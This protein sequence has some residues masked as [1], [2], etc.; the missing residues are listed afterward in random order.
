MVF[1]PPYDT[2]LFLFSPHLFSLSRLL[3]SLGCLHPTRINK[4]EKAEKKA[5][6]ANRR[7]RCSR[8]LGMNL[9]YYFCY[10][11]LAWYITFHTCTHSIGEPRGLWKCNVQSHN[12]MWL[13]FFSSRVVVACNDE[14]ASIFRVQARPS[15]LLLSSKFARGKQKAGDAFLVLFSS[16]RSVT[17]AFF[18]IFH[19]LETGKK[20]S[21][22]DAWRSSRISSADLFKLPRRQKRMRTFFFQ[23]KK[24]SLHLAGKRNKRPGKN[25]KK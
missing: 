24:S 10:T 25:R 7:R 12:G 5:R 1:T 19:A 14:S 4:K 16:L 22:R 23:S 18:S 20:N 6:D 21:G 13:F 17:I 15:G 9:G 2:F 8:W 11:G 3:K